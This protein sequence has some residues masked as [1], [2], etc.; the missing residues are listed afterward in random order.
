MLASAY[1]LAGKPEPL[2][3]GK[4]GGLPGRATGHEKVNARIDLAPRQ[5]PDTG[6]IERA[7]ARKRSDQRRPATCE[8]L[9][10]KNLLDPGA[11]IRV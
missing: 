7:A 11:G 6:F 5:P 10:H 4:R 8:C 1:Q 3:L 2:R 9:T